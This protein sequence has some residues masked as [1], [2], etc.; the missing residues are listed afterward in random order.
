M[1]RPDKLIGPKVAGGG[2][3]YVTD[4]VVVGG[5]EA[6]TGGGAEALAGGMV[7]VG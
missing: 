4:V 2:A 3:V 6:V 1:P 7:Y 5:T